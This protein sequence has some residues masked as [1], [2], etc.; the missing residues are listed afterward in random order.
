MVINIVWDFVKVYQ[1]FH[2]LSIG[3]AIGQ[4]IA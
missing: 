3:L 2:N 4:P 1:P